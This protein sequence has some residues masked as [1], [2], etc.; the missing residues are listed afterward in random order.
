MTIHLANDSTIDLKIPKVVKYLNSICNYVKFEELHANIN[1]SHKLVKFPETHSMYAQQIKKNLARNDFLIIVTDLQY[2]NNYFY[3]E[4]DG[5]I[6]M[7]FFAWKYLTSLPKENGLI[8]LV[9]GMLIDGVVPYNAVDHTRRL[10][11]VNDFLVDKTRVDDGMRKGHLCEDCKK[12]IHEHRLSE[13]QSFLYNDILSMLRH[14]SMASAREQ[15]VISNIASAILPDTSFSIKPDQNLARSK[16]RGDSIFISYSHRDE[17]YRLKLEDHLKVLQKIGMIS[18]WS[19]RKI[20]PGD[21]WSG[22]IDNNLKNARIVLMLI[23]SNFMASGYCYDVEM[24]TALE[25]HKNNEATVIPIILRDCLWQITEFAKLQA[26]PQDGKPIQNFT[27]Q[28]EAYTSIAR[29]IAKIIRE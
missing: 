14:L 6:I 3:E 20:A 10:G 19:D 29:A 11:C 17:R 4:K 25:R 1:A 7:S 18:I 13:D 26:L 23:S 22:Q 16:N 12:Y 5:L 9:C 8:Y 24:T 2:D 21:E 28:D 27:R 15:S